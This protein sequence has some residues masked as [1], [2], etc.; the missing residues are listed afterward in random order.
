[1]A[2]TS[3][4]QL[5]ELMLSLSTGKLSHETALRLAACTPT[6]EEVIR[7]A[8]PHGRCA[9]LISMSV[10][11]NLHDPSSPWLVVNPPYVPSNY[12]R[13]CI[14]PDPTSARDLLYEVRVSNTRHV[15]VPGTQVKVGSPTYIA[16]SLLSHAEDARYGKVCDVDAALVLPDGSPRVGAGAF[17][18][19]QAESLKKAG[20]RF[21]GIEHLEEDAKR[22]HAG[23]KGV[24]EQELLAYER[25]LVIRASYAPKQVALRAGVAGGV[26]VI[27]TASMS[28]YQR[29]AHYQRA[30]RDGTVNDTPGARKAYAERAAKAVATQATICGGITAASVATEAAAFHIASQFTSASKAHSIAAAAVA[31][32]YAAMDIAAEFIAYKRGEISGSEAIV[33]CGAKVVADALPI[34][35]RAVAGP[36]GSA[37]GLLV[38]T[39]IRWGVSYVRRKGGPQVSPC[40]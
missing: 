1:M 36:A 30:V 13:S 28:S 10:R 12:V 9:E 24:Y 37:I 3:R 5:A 22:I 16:R 25:E 7:G 31:A 14:N 23:L 8:N 33:C 17:T 40:V 29:Y 11:N 26:S 18:K 32:G 6:V 39:G 38:S 4:H 20:F 34:V 35:L 19:G 27:L 2:I 15:F 21:V